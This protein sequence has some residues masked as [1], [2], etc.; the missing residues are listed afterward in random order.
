MNKCFA[1]IITLLLVN[2]EWKY[3]KLYLLE[4]VM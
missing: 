4:Y 2:D 1:T 3:E